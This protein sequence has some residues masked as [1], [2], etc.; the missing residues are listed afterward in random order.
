MSKLKNEDDGIGYIEE[1]HPLRPQ[2]AAALLSVTPGRGKSRS[3]QNSM[4][5]SV[6]DLDV[7]IYV[8][9]GTTSGRQHVSV[10]L[11][12][13]VRFV[14]ASVLMGRWALVLAPGTL[15]KMRTDYRGQKLVPQH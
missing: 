9:E 7:P 3:R 14:H 10:P 4:S 1:D 12:M 15:P 2:A 11:F 8:R 6:S 5:S 13:F